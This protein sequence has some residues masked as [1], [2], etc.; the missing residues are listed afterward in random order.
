MLSSP[1]SMLRAQKKKK[2]KN[3]DLS[4]AALYFKKTAPIV[5]AIV[6]GKPITAGSR[7][8]CSSYSGAFTES[9]KGSDSP[10]NEDKH[11]S[12]IS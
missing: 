10:T 1:V 5:Y 6:P 8:T 12:V 3:P 4:R 2:K 9:L 11:E 7:C